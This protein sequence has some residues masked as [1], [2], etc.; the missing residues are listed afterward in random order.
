MRRAEVRT[1]RALGERNDACIG[2]NWATTVCMGTPHFTFPLA[3]GNGNAWDTFKRFPV[4]HLLL[5]RSADEMG[6]MW[7]TYPDQM[8]RCAVLDE[9]EIDDYRLV[10][11]EC[12]PPEDAERPAWPFEERREP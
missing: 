4:T 11:L 8:R 5:E 7:E 2:G 1:V 3:R 10:L 9:F 6:Y 12:H